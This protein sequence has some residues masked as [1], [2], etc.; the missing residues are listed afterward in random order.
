MYNDFYIYVLINVEDGTFEKYRHKPNSQTLI[1][2]YEYITNLKWLQFKTRNEHSFHMDRIDR[3]FWFVFSW[4]RTLTLRRFICWRPSTLSWRP[5]IS[6]NRWRKKRRR[7]PT[8]LS[9]EL[10]LCMAGTKIPNVAHF[11]LPSSILSPF[12]QSMCARSL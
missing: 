9:E 7:R 2:I 11:D 1:R 8:S 5:N 12:I 3:G 10:R 4:L 6:K